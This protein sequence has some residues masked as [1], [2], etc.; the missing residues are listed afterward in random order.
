[1]NISMLR[2]RWAA[3][4]AAVAIT[5]G[6]GGLGISYAVSPSGA[7]TLVPI[8]PCRILDSRPAPDNIG[9]RNTPIGAGETHV[10]TA[11]G[12]N[13]NCTGIPTSAT[14]LS[15]NVTALN[16]TNPTFVTVW[17]NGAAQ[18]TSS[19][20]NPLPGQGPVPN[21]VTTS[22]SGDGKFNI[23]NG[24]GSVNVIVDVV[25]YYSNHSH[26]AAEIVDEPGI[27]TDY[28]N[29]V[30]SATA[31]PGVVVGTSM[32]APA[33]GYVDVEVTG[34]WNNTGATDEVWC[35][36]QKGA[37]GAIDTGEPWFILNDH[38]TAT[39]YTVFSAHR[40]MPISVAD[41]P[42]LFTLGQSISLVCDEIQ[43]DVVFDEVAITATYFPSSYRPIGLI[44]ITSE[45]V[46]GGAAE[47]G[48]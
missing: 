43:G 20:L 34:M 30:F 46:D 9:N 38:N 6:A 2:T 47:A 25:G 14:G 40:T 28:R 45:G 32:R 31:T 4:G 23:F 26:N 5:L 13:G 19:N 8:T 33:D 44:I 11:H 42:F 27:A 36:I 7:S 16:A 29:S 37:T 39:G 35:Q 12:N 24:Y 48:G 18:P 17:A 15:L 1:M 10:V 41:N 21:S 3:V 22:L